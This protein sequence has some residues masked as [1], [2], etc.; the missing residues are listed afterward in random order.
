MGPCLGLCKSLFINIGAFLSSSN[1]VLGLSVLCQVKSSNFLSFLNLLFV[2]LDLSLELINECLHALVV[3]SVLI[4]LVGKL[5]DLALRL[6]QVLLRISAAPVFSIKLRFQLPDA[7]V[8]PG[9]GLL[10]SLQGIQVCAHITVRWC[11][12]NN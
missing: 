3:L 10:S 12:S 8:H 11:P 5:L 9:H 1:I 2:G 6:S 7:S 4:L